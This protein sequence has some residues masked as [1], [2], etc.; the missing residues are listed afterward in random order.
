[1]CVCVCVCSHACEVFSETERKETEM[2]GRRGGESEWEWKIEVSARKWETE[3]RNE[4]NEV[5]GERKVQP[6]GRRQE[7]VKAR[8]KTSSLLQRCINILLAFMFARERGRQCE[9]QAIVL[10]GQY[11]LFVQLAWHR[12]HCHRATLTTSRE[13]ERGDSTFKNT[14]QRPVSIQLWGQIL[15]SKCFPVS[16]REETGS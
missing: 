4:V 11:Q 8:I 2:N 13:E 14:K 10:G 12:C 7:F 3:S 6:K 9:R 16:R 15:N 5:E 1:M